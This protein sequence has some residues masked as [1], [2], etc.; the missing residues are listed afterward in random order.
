MSYR[1]ILYSVRDHI[2]T[3]SL[4]RPHVSNGYTCTMGTELGAAIT[5]ADNNPEVRAIILTG[6]GS[7][8]CVGMDLCSGFT[9]P[10]PEHDWLEPAGQ[11]SQRIFECHKPV[12]AAIRGAAIGAGSTII[13]PADY[14]I[15]ATD[16]RFGYVFTRRGFFPEGASTWHLPRIV[17]MGCA[18]D[19]MLTGRVF[20]AAEALAS[21]LV[22]RVV[23]PD[24][25]L[26]A[27]QQY[28]RDLITNTAPVSVAVTR[29]MLLRLSAYDTPYP[30]HTLESKLIAGLVTSPDAAEGIMSFLQRRTPNFPGRVPADIP[31]IVGWEAASD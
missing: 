6:E 12:I 21:G 8:F 30:A 17:G 2:A 15:A 29:Q 28:A 31:T 22:H 10:P 9:A 11:C 26:P 14:R 27:A 23:E 1:D 3:V 4:N 5:A 19:W 18:M 24:E 16:S 7:D 13:L 25:V 20:P